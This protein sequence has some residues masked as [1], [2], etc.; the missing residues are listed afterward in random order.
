MK[1][2][3]TLGARQ[4]VEMIERKSRFIGHAT[5]VADEEQ[6]LAFLKEIREAHREASHNCYAYIIGQNEGIMRYNDDGEPG[7]TAGQP[8][9]SVLRARHVVDAAVVV[10]R[11][12]GG[13]LLGAG[14]LV[15][16]YGQA[17]ALAIDAARV[18]TIEPTVTLLVEVAYPLWDSFL[19]AL[20]T[21]PV[22][23]RDTEFA[24]TVVATLDL[25]EADEAEMLALFAR[26]TDGQAETLEISRGYDRWE[27]A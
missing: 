12:F 2:Y 27:S 26:V 8:I 6:A 17:A 4:S 10:T 16:A 13:I 23:I 3:Q 1:S 21:A 22:R 11:Y 15:R 14:G 5:P 20:K 7:G 25:R 19:H 9:L 24:A 18:V